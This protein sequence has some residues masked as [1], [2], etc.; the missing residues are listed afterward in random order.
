MILSLKDIQ[1]NVGRFSLTAVGIGMLLMIVM[2]MGGIYRG[3]VEDATLLIERVDADLW[4]VQRE[5]RGPFAE[6]S[7]VAPNLVHRVRAVPGVQTSREFVYHTVQRER[8]GRLLRMAILG[9]DWPTDPGDWL[10]LVSGR[11]IAQGHYEMV[12]DRSLGLELGDKLRLGKDDYTV[13]GL[14]QSMISASG[15]GIATFSIA[16]AQAVQFDTP[17]EAVRLE[18]AA[19][20]ARGE[21]FE[22]TVRQ[23]DVLD[24]VWK[25]AQQLPAVA[26]PQISAVMV[27]LAPGAELERVRSIIAGWG[28]VSVFTK[29]GQRELLL[30]GTVDRARRQIGLFR[31][32]LTIIA[33]IIMAL[34]LYTLTLDKIHSIAL[35]KLIGASN[36]VILGMILQQALILGCV[37]LGIAYAAGTQL[38]PLFPRRVILAN[39][40]LA[41]LVIIVFAISVGASVLGIW[42]A[43]RVSPNEALT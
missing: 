1:H 20:A 21:S 6:L 12:A 5:T 38:F 15:D 4:V 17:G 27:T 43:L 13:V 40:D 33:A 10:P 30:R 41:Q 22:L 7:R 29:D 9:L 23:P 2:G 14:T 24:N 25:P 42:K 26:R 35:L 3:I 31:A 19:R 34:I 11:P 28:D 36:L 18:R 8:E 32:L 37:G 39:D 16:D